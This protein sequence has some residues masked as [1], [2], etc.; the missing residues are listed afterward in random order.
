SQISVLGVSLKMPNADELS[1]AC[2]ST[3]LEFSR[4]SIPIWY[5]L[6]MVIEVAD[7]PRFATAVVEVLH[8]P[9]LA[10][11]ET[12]SCSTP[13]ARKRSV[14]PVGPMVLMALPVDVL[15]AALCAPFLM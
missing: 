12:E 7:E 10:V 15:A 14:S 2:D 9:E 13:T 3:G 11:S 8:S 6:R 1:A 4:V 5:S